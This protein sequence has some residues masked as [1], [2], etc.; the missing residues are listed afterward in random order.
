MRLVDLDPAWLVTTAQRD[1]MG[2]SFKC[3]CGKPG[4][5]TYIGVLFVNP[6]DGGPPAPPEVDP[7]T[8]WLRTGETFDTLTIAPSIDASAS[9]HWHGFIRNGNIE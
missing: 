8:R 3:P 2:I 4:C 6:V 9:G 5:D 1:G 7:R